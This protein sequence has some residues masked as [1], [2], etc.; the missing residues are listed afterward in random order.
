MFSLLSQLAKAPFGTVEF[1]IP[2]GDSEAVIQELVD[3]F[4]FQMPEANRKAMDRLA[5][6]GAPAV[7][8]L[9]EAL[10]SWD[11]KTWK[12]AM[13]VHGMIGAPARPPAGG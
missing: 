11:N 10:G 8:A 4:N 12:Q 5:E 3:L 6:I 1:V 9:I 13:K 7:P 2:D